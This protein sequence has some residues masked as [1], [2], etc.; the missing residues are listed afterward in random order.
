MKHLKKKEEFKFTGTKPHKEILDTFQKPEG[1]DWVTLTADEVTSLCPITHQPDYH[2]ITI[3]YY[4][5]KKCVESKSL[6]LYL[7]GYRMVGTFTETLASLISRDLNAVLDTYVEVKV[8][9]KS[10]GGIS[11]E[12]RATKGVI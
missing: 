7:G 2:T 12:G 8:N 1:V 4:A 5:K 3:T 10:R 9:S 6:K 11:I